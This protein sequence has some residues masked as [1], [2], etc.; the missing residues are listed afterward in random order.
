MRV[1]N[2]HDFRGQVEAK[3]EQAREIYGSAL[4]YV[5]R[6]SPLGNPFASPRDGD[7]ATVIA[8]YRSWLWAKL[9]QQDATTL[10]AL[11]ALH[12]GS[13]LGCWCCDKDE[14][15]AKG[16]EDCHGEIIV[17]AWQ[18][19]QA[20]LQAAVQPLV[21]SDTQPEPPT[22]KPKRSSRKSSP[23]KSKPTASTSK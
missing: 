12:E 5:G 10:A 2:L 17:K 8:K 4:T 19:R 20:Q 23:R 7:R 15:A 14:P 1:I 18:W 9:G 3:L 22:A 13:V 16:Q 21:D 11:D 6:P